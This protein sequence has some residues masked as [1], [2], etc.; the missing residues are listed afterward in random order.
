MQQLIDR[1]LG[2]NQRNRRSG[3]RV[4]PAVPQLEC[5]SWGAKSLSKGAKT[6]C[7]NKISKKKKVFAPLTVFSLQVFESFSQKKVFAYDG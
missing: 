1:K 6:L 3:R 7:I 2:H 5:S 4:N